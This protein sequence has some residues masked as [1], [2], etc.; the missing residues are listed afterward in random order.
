MPKKEDLMERANLV[1]S[2]EQRSDNPEYKSYKKTRTVETTEEF[3]LANLKDDLA[4][5]QKRREELETREQEIQSMIAE[6]EPIVKLD[7]EVAT[8]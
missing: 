2:D 4:L 3:S 6:L 7:N 5:T 1:L 8:L